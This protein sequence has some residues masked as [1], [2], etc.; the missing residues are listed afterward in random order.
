MNQYEI[1]GMIGEG[2]YGVV[3]K[4]RRIDTGRVVAIKKFKEGEDDEQV[5]K[6]ALREVRL[7]KQLRHANIVSLLEVFR[8]PSDLKL[9]LVFEFVEKTILEELDEHPYGLKETD[10]RIYSFQLVQALDYCHSLNVAH[11][12]E[13]IFLPF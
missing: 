3:L 6:T 4:A 2:T 8:R 12:Y 7:L 9:F 5:K 13:R 1:I 11:R 10:V